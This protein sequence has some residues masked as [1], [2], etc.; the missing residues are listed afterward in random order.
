MIPSV[1]G[2]QLQL[3][4]HLHQWPSMAS[5]SAKPQLFFMT[6]SCL[7]NQY[8]LG[9]PYTLPST[10]AAKG[11]TLAISGTWLLCSPRKYFPEDFDIV[12][13]VSY[14]YH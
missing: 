6:S 2:Y 14:N 5:H 1:L 7:H 3:R 11:T 13:L 12:M 4:L 9:D 8:H 10:A